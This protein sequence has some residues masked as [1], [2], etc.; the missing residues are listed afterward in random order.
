M[1]TWDPAVADHA[2]ALEDIS[3]IE[4]PV[5]EDGWATW[6]ATAERCRER[7]LSIVAAGVLSSSGST[8]ATGLPVEEEARRDAI[9][10]RLSFAMTREGVAVVLVG[11]TNLDH[12]VENMGIA[13][14]ILGAAR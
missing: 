8:E 7:G 13:D 12:L 10:R 6:G 11:T 14:S 2:I 5:H 3:R 9:R 4:M 1:S